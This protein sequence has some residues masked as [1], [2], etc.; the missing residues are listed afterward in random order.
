MKCRYC[1]H[2]ISDGELYCDNC[3]KEVRIVPDYNPLEDMLT[4][5]I[6]IALDGNNSQ[7]ADDMIYDSIRNTDDRRNTGRSAVRESGRNTARNTGRSTGANAGRNT[8]KNTGK[9]VSRNTGRQMSERDRRKQAERRKAARRRKKKQALALAASLLLLIGIVGIFAY[10]T[11]YIGTVNKGNKALNKKDYNQAELY[12][13]KAITKDEE[14]PDAYTGLSK[15]YL[16]QNND[17]KAESI[18][19]DAIDKQPENV[20]LYHACIQFY[21]DS[22]QKEEIPLLLD[23]AK[24]SITEALS[25]YIISKPK[26]SLDDSETFDDVQELTLT[27]KDGYT[28]YYTLDEKEPSISSTKYT[29]PIQIGE[30]ETVIKAI[31]VDPDGIPSLSAKKSYLVEL[32]IEDAP[33]VSPSTGQYDSPVQIEIIVPDGYDAYYTMDRTDPTTASTKYT[34]PIDMPVGETIFK[35]ILVNSDGRS[36]GITTRN[37]V[38][39]GN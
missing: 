9:N 21:I 2:E 7:E 38:C 28:I 5:Q 29:E 8:G 39:G 22:D 25:Q 24:D 30:G 16:A 14:R 4:A 33:A 1:G 17:D 6:K 20:E 31:A 3:G 19:L 11:S 35:A 34:G 10:Q 18:F 27:A 23:E 13:K 36:S 37:Y 15:V 12:F 26:F 32:P